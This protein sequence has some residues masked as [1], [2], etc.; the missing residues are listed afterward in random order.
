MARYDQHVFTRREALATV[1][2]AWCLSRGAGEQ[3]DGDELE[4]WSHRHAT[5]GADDHSADR[6]LSIPRGLG[7]EKLALR[8]HD[9]KRNAGTVR[10]CMAPEGAS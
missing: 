5:V 10:P 9:T 1:V 2:A 8:S 7:L 3:R 4:Q 6:V